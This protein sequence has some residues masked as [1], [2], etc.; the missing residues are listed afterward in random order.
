MCIQEEC[1]CYLGLVSLKLAFW[2]FSNTDLI[3]M[4]YTICQKIHT[5]IQPKIQ[6]INIEFYVFVLYI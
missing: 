1:K 3:E 5:K 2:G 4:L 6:Q